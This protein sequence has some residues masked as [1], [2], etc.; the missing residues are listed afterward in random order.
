MRIVLALPGARPSVM[1]DIHSNFSEQQVQDLKQTMYLQRCANGLIFSPEKCLVLRDTFL[2]MGSESI[3]VE[4]TLLTDDVLNL[5]R[6]GN[7]EDRVT[8][9]LALLSSSWSHA[10]STEKAVEPLFYDIVPAAAGTELYV[11]GGTPRSRSW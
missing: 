3:Q 1:V 9:W 4:K 10:L 7:L 6:A 2:E 5:V 11:M 8:T